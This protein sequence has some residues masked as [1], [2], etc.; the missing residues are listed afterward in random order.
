MSAMPSAI[1]ANGCNICSN[2][3]TINI[4]SRYTDITT[5]I[6]YVPNSQYW[7]AITFEYPKANVPVPTFE[8]TVR[9]NPIH[10]NFF[11]SQDMAQVLRG[12]FNED[13]FRAVATASLNIPN[14]PPN[15]QNRGGSLGGSAK[16]VLDIVRAMD[17]RFANV[18]SD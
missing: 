8:Y 10:A 17:D 13:S 9:I 2:L 15:L 11:T 4:N 14:A 7:F 5:T 3:F 16:N 1:L 18:V 6:R 12:A